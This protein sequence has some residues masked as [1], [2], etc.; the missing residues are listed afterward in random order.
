[1]NLLTT[2]ECRITGIAPLLQKS[3]ITV[4]ALHPRVQAF[5]KLS[6]KRAKTVADFENLKRAE[7]ELGMHRENDAPVTPV[8]WWLACI[9]EAAAKNK[10]RK[11]AKAGVF[12]VSASFPLEY[13]GPKDLEGMWSSGRFIDYRGVGQAQRKIMRARPRF[14][15]WSVRVILDVSESIIS[16]DDVL[17]A[18]RIAGTLIGVGDYRPRFGRFAVTA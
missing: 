4:D 6:T 13:D 10:L 16:R 12:P 8:D 15:Q 2:L 1:M 17:A 9:F 7:W 11:Q 3:E 14:D 18:L 5:K